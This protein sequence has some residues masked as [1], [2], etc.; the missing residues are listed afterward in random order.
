MSSREIAELTGKRHPDVR[1][2]I[3]NMI[4]SLALDVSSFAR[5]Y[6]DTA[7]RS[8]EEFSLPKRET[9]ILV[10]GYN[11]QMRARIIDRW[12]GESW[13]SEIPFADRRWLLSRPALATRFRSSSVDLKPRRYLDSL[14]VRAL[15]SMPKRLLI[16]DP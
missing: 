2:D 11:V 8:Q 12:Q 6:K 14:A 9:L 5:I 4:E 1:R 15:G 16:S 3:L 10:S 7:G 13:P